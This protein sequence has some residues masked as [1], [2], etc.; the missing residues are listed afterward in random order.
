MPSG[1]SKTHEEYVEELLHIN[2]N[3]KVLGRYV[4]LKTKISHQCL[5]DGYIWD[6]APNNALR[7]HG[8]PRCYGNTKRT[9]VEY[10]QTVSEIHP[11]IL[12]LEPYI[13]SNTKIKHR[14]KIDG[15]EW[16]ARPVDVLAG[17]KCP[18]CSGVKIGPPPKYINSIWD[19][20]YREYFS[21][22]L[23]EEQMKQYTPKSNQR[24]NIVCPD[25]G[26]NKYILISSLTSNGLGCRCSD[27][28]SYP[29]KFLY[30]IL[31]QLKINYESEY[32]DIWTNN[33]FYDIYCKD[34]NL[35]IENHGPQH[36]EE[37]TL[38]QRTLK[39]EQAND[40][41]KRKLAFQNGIKYYITIDCRQSTLE[42]IKNSIMNSELPRLLKFNVQNIDWDMAALFA[43]QNLVKQAAELYNKGYKISN[44]SE[45]LNISQSTVIRWLHQMTKLG[46]CIYDGKNEH[47]KKSVLCVELNKTFQSITEA[48]KYFNVSVQNINRCLSGH[49]KTACG[50][51]WQYI[52]PQNDL[53]DT[54]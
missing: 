23:T 1:K 41:Y 30:A 40:I 31:N 17:H 4:T 5:L 37:C 36:Y 15:C 24:I 32:H 53:R 20:K 16:M 7:G 26:N 11:N 43:T 45:K 38:T 21:K 2:P 51:H 22:F 27:G 10:C 46:L 48:A 42:W 8:C 52:T 13:N 19:S 18:V 12:V 33:R 25:C 54:D 39:E 50:Y 28:I 14:C 29:N 34:L 3:L 9:H 49:N 6:L 47:P 35:I 44:I